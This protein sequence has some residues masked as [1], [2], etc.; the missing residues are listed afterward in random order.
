[1]AG[2]PRLLLRWHDFIDPSPAPRPEKW[3]S[4]L[5]RTDVALTYRWKQLAAIF[6]VDN[7]FNEKYQQFVG[8]ENPG[9]RA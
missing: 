7:L 4:M 6:A 5:T 9:I 2:Y 8:F 3:F 1:M